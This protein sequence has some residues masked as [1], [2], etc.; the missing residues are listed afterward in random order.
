M[1]VTVTNDPPQG[2]VQ[3]G[4][5]EDVTGY[6]LIGLDKR[7]L[8]H[9]MVEAVVGGG[10]PPTQDDWAEQLRTIATGARAAMLITG[11]RAKLTESR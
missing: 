6:G 3:P 2:A 9:A 11:I 10:P 8:L 7:A 1:V 5:P 4:P